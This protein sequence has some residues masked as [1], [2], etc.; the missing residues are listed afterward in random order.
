M[1]VIKFQWSKCNTDAKSGL[2]SQVSA[3]IRLETSESADEGLP[4]NLDA[5]TYHP[6][7]ALKVAIRDWLPEFYKNKTAHGKSGHVV[8]APLS[9]VV[10]NL[11]V[12]PPIN[13]D[14][15]S[16]DGTGSNFIPIHKELVNSLVDPPLIIN[17][18]LE[19]MDCVSSSPSVPSS[20]KGTSDTQMNSQV[21]SPISSDASDKNSRNESLEDMQTEPLEDEDNRL[22]LDD[23]SLLVD[24]FYLPFEHGTH[25]MQFLTEFEW[26]KAN[27]KNFSSRDGRRNVTTPGDTNGS[28]DDFNE[29]KEKASNFDM[30]S[31]KVGK[32][33]TRLTF[34][35]NRSLLYDFYPYVWDIKGVIS[36]LN[37]YI[38]WMGEFYFEMTHDSLT[39]NYCVIM[40]F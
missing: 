3:D 39:D 28:P 23:V 15:D 40:F 34:I 33:L 16:R 30:M 29:W 14:S 7:C 31:K 35:K 5:N 26:L 4:P 27:Q 6:R 36:L 25:G 37:S 22:T 8:T 10:A 12:P 21:Q 18:I 24:L 19:P 9:A 32:L 1:L 2:T 11:T 13:V 20:P 17:P 38:K